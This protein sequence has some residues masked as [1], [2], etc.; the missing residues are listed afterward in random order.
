M[1]IP[2]LF[3]RRRR[4][5]RSTTFSLTPAGK[6]KAEEYGNTPAD[7]IM[8]ALDEIRTGN[9][10]EIAEE[11]KLRRSVVEKL[12]PRLVRGNYIHAVRNEDS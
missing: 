8:S 11:A 7:R 9:T 2:E 10:D 3:T 6:Q 12:L 4:I 1:N 5:S